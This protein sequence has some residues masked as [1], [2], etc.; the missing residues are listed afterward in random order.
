MALIEKLNAI[1]DAIRE[2]TGKTARM[3]LDEMPVEI[4]NLLQPELQTKT[5]SPTTSKQTV[6]PDSGYDGLSSV[7][8]NA[9]TTAAQA[10][11]SITVDSDG[12]ITASA[13]QTAGYV[14]AGTTSAT[15][16]LTTQAATTYIPTTSDQ[17]IASGTYCS[18][19]QTIEGDANLVASNIK[20]GVTIFG[21]TG[22]HAGGDAG[23]SEIPSGYRRAEY[24]QFNGN[25]W[26]D[27]G[28]V[29]NQDTQINVGFV[30]E[31]S[32]QRHLFGCASS[33]NTA[34][35][36]SYMNGSWRFGNKST[37]KNFST[38]NAMIPYSALVNNTTISTTNSTAA[39]SDVN[40]FETVGTLL[41]G[42]CRD[43]DGTL[44]NVGFIGKVFFFYLWQ[45]GQ[46]VRKLVPV[47]N[48]GGQYRFYD[49]ISKT[50]FD[51]ITATA[52]DGGIYC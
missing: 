25:Q 23:E 50:F 47:V 15:K 3:T 19:A 43:S 2:K 36:T 6:T 49:M 29:G 9:M 42:A 28:V 13:T 27:T 7:T 45:A 51:S 35:I 41:V 40:A 20:S 1:G 44:P 8:V 33:D 21:V 12:L 46:I 18:G 16:Q 37:S 34:S 31:S 4:A 5:V 52:L 32:T 22:I 26:I 10:T 39:I 30:W 14:S 38:K 24:I 17:I 48:E 11:P